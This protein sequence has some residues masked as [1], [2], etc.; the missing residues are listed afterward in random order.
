LEHIEYKEVKKEGTMMSEFL[1]VVLMKIQVLWLVK[2]C[3]F[4]S[5]QRL[6]GVY[7]HLL[8]QAVEEDLLNCVTLKLVALY[9][10]I[11]T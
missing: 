9:H 1:T 11:A 8:S 5:V 2:P 7:C 10:L 3:Q 4:V 6:K